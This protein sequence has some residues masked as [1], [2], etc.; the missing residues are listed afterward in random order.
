MPC[1]VYGQSFSC[2]GLPTVFVCGQPSSCVAVVS[3]RKRSFL[4][5]GSWLDA[6]V[7]VGVGGVIVARGVVVSSCVGDCLRAW[8]LFPCVS[9]C[10]RVWAVVSVR[11]RSAWCVGGYWHWWGCCCAWGRCPVGSL[12]C[13]SAGTIAEG[14][15]VLTVLK[16][17]DERRISIRRSSFGC[18]VTDSDVAPCSVCFACMLRLL[19]LCGVLI[20]GCGVWRWM[21]RAGAGGRRMWMM[22]V[23]WKGCGIRIWTEFPLVEFAEILSRKAVKSCIYSIKYVGIVKPSWYT[24]LSTHSYYC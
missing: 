2:V 6:W 20:G 1:I 16:N 14:W 15:V 23:T 3:V 10:F 9:G 7:V 12:S 17:N 18:H 24:W 8:W 11:G 21:V 13:G 22:V 5:M 19:W 4:C